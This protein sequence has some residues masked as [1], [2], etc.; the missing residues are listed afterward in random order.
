MTVE[1]LGYSERGMVNALCTDI[2][3]SSEPLDR[4][5]EF[6]GWC[7]FPPKLGPQIDKIISARLIVEQSFSDFGTPDLLILLDYEKSKQLIIVEAKVSA[8]TEDQNSI[9]RQWDDSEAYFS[10]GG[11]KSSALFV[12][13]YRENRLIKFINDNMD[14][15]KSGKLRPKKWNIGKN[16]VVISAI[17]A[18]RPYCLASPLFLVIIPD[19][20]E[21]FNVISK[22][23]TN[24]NYTSEE[25]PD[26]S[27]AN[28]GFLGWAIIDEKTQS[29]N[30]DVKWPQVRK[31]FDWN[32]PNQIY[33]TDSQNKWYS[34]CN[35]NIYILRRSKKNSSALEVNNNSEFFPKKIVIPTNSLIEPINKINIELKP[36]NGSKYDLVWSRELELEQG[37]EIRQQKPIVNNKYCVQ[38]LRN[39]LIKSRVKI[40]L[41]NNLGEIECEVSNHHIK[42]EEQQ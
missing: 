42:K 28:L 11:K 29:S 1:L 37:N 18:L 15:L 16:P 5:K 38:V 6:L 30:E 19:T 40:V 27:M 22:M 21:D 9:G 2:L 4:L 25:L 36:K 32:K 13:L 39:G 12:Q 31:N 17:K 10:R 34:C 3:F 33:F 35:K 7:I 8:G 41:E 14:T 26:W 24:I 20:I 23:V